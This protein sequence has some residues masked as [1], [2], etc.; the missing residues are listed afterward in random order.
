M[1][2][3]AV[4]NVSTTNT[5]T[6]AGLS[7]YSTFNVHGLMPATLQS[8]VPYVSDMLHENDQLFIGLTETWLQNHK[9]AELS[10]NGYS[11][12]RADR[13]RKKKSR[14]RLSGGGVAY[15]RDDLA[16]KMEINL[17]FSN[18][19]V[20][21]L[22]LYSKTDNLYIAVVYRQPDDT[23][24]GNRSTSTEFNAALSHL[25]TSLNKTTT[26]TPN[27]VICGDFN[28]P[29]YSWK[30]GSNLPGVFADEKI[31]LEA[32]K[33]FSDDFFLHQH[34]CQPT[35]VAGNTLDLLF[36]N[37]PHLLH[38]YIVLQP[39]RSISDHYIIEVSTQF[40]SASLNKHEEEKPEPLSQ[41]DKL[42]FFSEDID[43]DTITLE[44]SRIDW[45]SNLADESPDQM[46]DI[47]MSVILNS[48]SKHVPLKKSTTKS[49][50]KIPR[51][52]KLLMRKRRKLQEQLIKTS[53]EIRKSNIK[54][55]LVN[56]EI[57]LQKSHEE[58]LSYREKKALNAI[59]TNSKYFFAYA[60]KF[61]QTSKSIGP[62]L[63]KN[64][65]YTCSSKEMA[66]ILA[67][68]YKSVFSTPIEDSIYSN[69][70]PST[71]D[72]LT[73]QDFSFDESHIVE[74]INELS[75]TS[76]SGPDGIPAILLKK[77]KESLKKP[78]FLL[79]RKLLD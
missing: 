53:S 68:Q 17:Q 62:L 74:A 13:K 4:P 50:S 12:F 75:N 25:S 26:P 10:I 20:E 58:T 16:S 18:G 69:I 45:Q 77:C 76:S 1:A 59:K 23:S 78:L 15:V 73:I 65:E 43:W 5:A 28:L 55:K 42:N 9:D 66:D 7:T 40:K 67:N 63:N 70:T 52:R 61:S 64:N 31:M 3:V 44:L 79:Y 22:G 34:I 38:S 14:G 57:S 72:K 11:V 29:H 60:K 41:F 32:L 24:G 37:N 49:F 39:L 8:K 21:V 48:S 47:L 35:H 51:E 54:H 71:N 36:T 33:K 56:I 46:L 30:D 27:L 2:S 19:V 6:K